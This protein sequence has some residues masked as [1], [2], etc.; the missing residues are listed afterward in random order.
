MLPPGPSRPAVLQSWA[1]ARSPG[2]FL[3]DCARRFGSRFTVRFVGGRDFVFVSKPDEVK[4]VFTGSP[5][6]FLSGQANRRFE[7]FL[8]AHSLF[9]LD[10]EEHRRD[11]ALLLPPFRGER[12][13]A[14]GEL[15]R[16]LALRALERW[17]RGR[18]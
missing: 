15:M 17:P 11:R 16:D 3:D 10:G 5:D 2:P 4:A 6:V 1:W 12:M 9:V 8:G 13:R 18:P 14:Y 7:T